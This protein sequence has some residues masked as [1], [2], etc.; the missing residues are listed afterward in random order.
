MEVCEE[1]SLLKGSVRYMV[2]WSVKEEVQR[3][4][5]REDGSLKERV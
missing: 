5:V 1:K 3:E 2:R 4:C